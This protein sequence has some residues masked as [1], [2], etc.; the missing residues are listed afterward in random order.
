MSMKVTA[1]P[2][3][4]SYSTPLSKTTQRAEPVD[5]LIATGV[6]VSIR[7]KGQ[8]ESVIGDNNPDSPIVSKKI[9]DSL[10]LGLINFSQ[11]ERDCLASILSDKAKKSD[12]ILKS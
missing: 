11:E 3:S 1:S 6:G 10:S 9:L 7:H 8:G 12:H 2:P 4:F 5:Q